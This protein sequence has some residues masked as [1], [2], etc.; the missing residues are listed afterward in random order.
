MALDSRD[1][2]VVQRTFGTD[3]DKIFK[4]TADQLADYIAAT[5]AVH[6][7]GKRDFTNVA[8]TPGS[9]AGDEA[10]Q[11]GDLWVNSQVTPGRFA[12]T[13]DHTPRDPADGTSAL[14]VEHFDKCI[15]NANAS[16]WDVFTESGST[17][18][19]TDITAEYPLEVNRDEPA[20]PDITIA[21]AKETDGSV[22][23]AAAPSGD[24]AGVVEAIA[25]ESDVVNDPS[26]NGAPSPNPYAV[27]PA[28]LLLDAN[29]RIDSA[30]AG[31]VT[32]INPVKPID[33]DTINLW[34]PWNDDA[35]TQTAVLIYD[36][37]TDPNIPIGEERIAIKYAT[38]SQ[39]GV[40]YLT[41]AST[42]AFIDLTGAEQSVESG[43]PGGGLDNRGMMTLRRTF[44]NFVPRDFETLNDISTASNS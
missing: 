8:E 17:G 37:D 25:I 3:A 41:E 20:E 11:Q 14:P 5:P 16:K 27:V 4:A 36:H 9:V 12:W 31:G 29:R 7:M 2:F 6:Y 30:V 28:H 34:K 15:W 26:N 43:Q 39:A 13:P 22:V 42:G 23:S 1:L 24:N 38:E 10:P 44:V 40:S 35:N 32:D 19:L 18:T 21:A 33:A